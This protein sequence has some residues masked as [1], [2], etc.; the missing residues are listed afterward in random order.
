MANP[1]HAGAIK[2]S[3][4]LREPPRVL[5][6]V[7]ILLGHVAAIQLFSIRIE[8]PSGAQR[9]A[10][11]AMPIH[12]M[13][14]T[15]REMPLAAD[16]GESGVSSM[17]APVHG[18]TEA[19]P[20]SLP[21]STAIILPSTASVAGPVESTDWVAESGRIARQLAEATSGSR[22]FGDGAEE[23]RL[24]DAAAP[25]FFE[26]K[27]PRKAGYVEMLGPGVERRWISSRCY[28]EFGKPRDRIAGTRADLNSTQCLVGPGPVRDDLFDHLKPDYLE[29]N[30]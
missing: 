13:L 3:V 9:A 28:R 27:S 17:V 16:R 5:F 20:E 25:N 4:T 18:M 19:L 21:E 23:E 14:M 1:S 12:L 8:G 22:A 10:P 11:S 30:D 7:I 29:G 2:V 26:S 6:V 24:P 15:S